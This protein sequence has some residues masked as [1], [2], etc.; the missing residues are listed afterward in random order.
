MDSWRFSPGGGAGGNQAG[1]SNRMEREVAAEAQSPCY[2]AS[3]GT[4]HGLQEGRDLQRAGLIL[5]FSPFQGTS[6]YSI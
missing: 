5:E 2:L 6:G 1:E 3:P 4:A